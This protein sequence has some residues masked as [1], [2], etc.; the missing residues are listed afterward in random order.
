MRRQNALLST[1]FDTNPL[2][3]S[4]SI[5]NAKNK[6]KAMNKIEDSPVKQ[7]KIMLPFKVQ[8]LLDII[9]DKRGLG[10]EDALEYLYSSELYR[11]LSSEPYLWRLSTD[12]LYDLLKNEKRKKKHSQNNSQPILLFIA[13]CI[14][15]YREHRN[16]SADEVLYLFKK[17]GVINY[18]ML[19]FDL[20][21]TQGKEYIMS[22][23]DRYIKNRK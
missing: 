6:D 8:Q 4:T 9:I 18:L 2:R 11:K 14:E 13:F 21:H 17:Y 5:C 7:E 12:N 3:H 20:L 1:G 22:D 16:I 23:I 15:N 10:I 19:G